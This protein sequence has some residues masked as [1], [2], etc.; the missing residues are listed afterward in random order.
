[1]IAAFLPMWNYLIVYYLISIDFSLYYA[2][3]LN[4]GHERVGA[5]GLSLG[6]A[7]R[8]TRIIPDQDLFYKQY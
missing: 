1:M 6:K 5:M 4:F 7:T 3:K 8:M 2:G